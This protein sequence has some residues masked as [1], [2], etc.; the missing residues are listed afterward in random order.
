MSD[1]SAAIGRGIGWLNQNGPADWWDRIDLETLDISDP[2][3]CVLGQIFAAEADQAGM[4]TGYLFTQ[5]FFSGHGGLLRWSERRDM[6]LDDDEWSAWS[7]WSNQHA[8]DLGLGF[9]AEWANDEWCYNINKIKEE[10][11]A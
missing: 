11:R 9:D 8:F 7:N 1:L 10:V 6:M 3:K 5:T 2:S 4:N